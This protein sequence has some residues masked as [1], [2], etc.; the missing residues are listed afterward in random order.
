MDI[1]QLLA[2]IEVEHEATL[3]R[4]RKAKAEVELILDTAR[5]EGRSSL[6]EEESTRT[7]KLF[8]NIELAKVQENGIKDKL[9]RAKKIEAEEAEFDAR[10]NSVT[11][12]PAARKMPKYDEVARVG[13]EARTYHK[14]NDPRGQAFLR[15]VCRQY[16][17][18]DVGA[19]SRLSH[20]MAEER[21]ERA[22][23][24]ERA[25]GDIATT[26]LGGLVVPQY[27]IDMVAPMAAA[28]RPFADVCAHHQLPAQGMTVYIPTIT[29]ATSEAIQATQLTAVSTTSI[30]ETDA[31]IAVQTAAGS[32][33]VSRQAI[34][35][36]SGIDEVVLQDLM[37][38]YNTVLDSTLVNQATHGLSAIALGTLG[39]YADT[40]PT[41]VKTYPKI[42][43]AASGVEAALLA[44]GQPTHAVMHSR[45]W[46]WLSAQMTS[47]WPLINSGNIPA[48]A[49]GTMDPNVKY[50]QGVRGVL[51][52]GMK[53]LV[54]N[55]ISTA[56]NAN[57]DE[58]YVVP[59]AECHLWEDGGAPVFIRAEQPNAANLGVLLVVYGYFAYTFER[60]PSGAFQK[61]GGTGL[62]TP[63][64]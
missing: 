23:Y 53:V 2:S 34:D 12:T 50:N 63:A 56:V 10:A 25:A 41:G 8:E 39:A 30:G 14:G 40:Q 16:L 27:L 20:H 43:A 45:R 42:L 29:T 19:A 28:M 6:S 64:F 62:T 15:D 5:Q 1:K 3:M 11:P 49:A 55:N 17:Y 37:N 31:T 22:N 33:N 61:V 54:D 21:V 38:R 59:Q 36:G 52:N 35:R 18:N 4:Q 7:D 47:T 58:I 32:Q 57:Q 24:L 60:Y 13:N 44:M 9:A 51:P 26:G 46:Y 48:W